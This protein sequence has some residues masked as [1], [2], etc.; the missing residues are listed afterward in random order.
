MI[1][2]YQNIIWILFFGVLFTYITHKNPKI[3]FTPLKI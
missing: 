2:K 3:L 1:N